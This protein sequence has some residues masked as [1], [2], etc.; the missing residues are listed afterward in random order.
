MSFI[1]E[2]DF[3]QGRIAYEL[4]RYPRHHH[5]VCRQCRSMIAIDE[6]FFSELESRLTKEYGFAANLEHFAIWG[7]CRKCQGKPMPAESR[8]PGMTTKKRQVFVRK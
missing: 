5:L 7:L 1:T 4:H 3:G 8:E 6:S 2:T